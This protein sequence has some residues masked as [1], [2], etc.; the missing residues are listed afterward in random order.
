MGFSA[1]FIQETHGMTEL[2]FHVFVALAFLLVYRDWRAPAF[3]GLVIALH[4]L[5]F[6]LL[7]KSG[8]DFWVFPRAC[9]DGIGRSRCTPGSLSSRSPYSSTWPSRWPLRPAPRRR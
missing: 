5:G 6:Y 4:H 1:L 3:A 7:Q 9:H 8:A 2:H